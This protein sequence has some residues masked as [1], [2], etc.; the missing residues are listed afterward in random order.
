MKTSDKPQIE[1]IATKPDLG[2]RDLITEVVLSDAFR[3]R[4]GGEF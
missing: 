4:R 2:F 1:A 3:M